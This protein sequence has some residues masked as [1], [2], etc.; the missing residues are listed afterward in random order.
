[1]LIPGCIFVNASLKNKPRIEHVVLL[2]FVFTSHDRH[3][4]RCSANERVHSK[5][6]RELKLPVTE[7]TRLYALNYEVL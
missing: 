3:Q 2:C 7:H 5:H 6:C 1:M 4:E